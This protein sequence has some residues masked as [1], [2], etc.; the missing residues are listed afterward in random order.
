MQFRVQRTVIFAVRTN[1]DANYSGFIMDMY[2]MPFPENVNRISRGAVMTCES[3][4]GVELTREMCGTALAGL[5][6]AV[7]MTAIPA[8]SDAVRRSPR[9][10]LE[11]DGRIAEST[12]SMAIGNGVNERQ[13]TEDRATPCGDEAGALIGVLPGV[14]YVAPLRQSSAWAARAQRESLGRVSR[15]MTC[16]G[17]HRKLFI[18]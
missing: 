8:A 4:A 15:L 11:C 17:Q 18:L 12:R 13:V 3:L 16:M 9:T 1:T 6:A 5:K 2:M 7:P 14:E 10:M